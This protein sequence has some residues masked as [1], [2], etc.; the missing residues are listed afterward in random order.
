MIHALLVAS[1]LLGAAQPALAP[2]PKTTRPAPRP[3]PAPKPPPAPEPLDEGDDEPADLPDEAA[4]NPDDD[5]KEPGP[6][7]SGGTAGEPQFSDKE[8][9]GLGLLSLCCCFLIAAGIIGFIVFLV[10]RAN[11]PAARAAPPP[12][13]PA[14][15]GA[16]VAAAR[17]H[18][19]VLAL[20][21]H[22]GARQLV[23]QQLLIAGAQADPVSAAERT[24]LVRELAK[25]VRGLESEWVYFGYGERLD[26]AD[27]PAAQRSYQL[28]VEDFGKRSAEPSATGESGYAVLT[29]VLCMRRQLRGVSALDDRAQIRALLDDRALLYENELMGAY[30]TWAG[31]LG[32]P[33]VLTRFPEMHAVR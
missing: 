21:M 13:P 24:R 23:A 30:L 7:R 33:E 6:Y 12:P 16:P 20:G 28:A 3:A 11:R 2:R 18:L 26:L 9:Q 17:L 15:V 14:P 29:L 10:R 31:P 32:G 27:E 22:A 4:P 25:A 8:L 1:L 19:S 5:E